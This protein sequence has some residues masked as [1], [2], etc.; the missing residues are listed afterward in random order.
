MLHNFTIDHQ[1]NH[2]T[3]RKF[4]D[5]PLTEEQLTT[6]FEVARQTSSSEF[7]QQMTIIR[8]TDPQKR[9]AI[10]AVSTQP[11]VGAE[12][13]LLMFITDLHRNELIRHH[14]GNCYCTRH[15]NRIRRSAPGYRRISKAEKRS[16]DNN[17]PG[18]LVECLIS[19][20]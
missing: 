6:L 8:V 9:A 4:K 2:R 14:Q 15:S 20:P 11:Y 16:S 19:R 17:L 10:R 3:I 1:L 5:Q 13:E 18:L 7:L 12:G